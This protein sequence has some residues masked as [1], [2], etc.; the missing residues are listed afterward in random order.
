MLQWFGR[1]QYEIS[2]FIAGWCSLATID[3]LTQ[4]NYVWAAVN[5]FL[6][7]LNIKLAQ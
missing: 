6:V 2:F 3:C 4:G 7:W 1:W 5:A